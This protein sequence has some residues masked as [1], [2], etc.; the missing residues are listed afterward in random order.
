MTDDRWEE[1][2]ETLQK[3]GEVTVTQEP[4]LQETGDGF[5]EVGTQDVA[6]FKRGNMKYKVVRENRPVVLGKQTFVSHRQGDT[7]RTE[8]KF[9]DTEFSH[10][11]RVFKEIDF[12]EWEEMSAENLG[13]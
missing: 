12:D 8:Y 5:K 7:A 4:L 10:K 1:L 2:M 3:Q 6:V 9:S 11:V 13:L